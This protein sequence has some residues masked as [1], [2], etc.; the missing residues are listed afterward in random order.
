MHSQTLGFGQR[1]TLQEIQADEMIAASLANGCR[2]RGPGL[3]IGA[4][5]Y[6]LTLVT[7]VTATVPFQWAALTFIGESW[8][9]MMCRT[10]LEG[11]T[12]PRV[13]HPAGCPCLDPVRVKAAYVTTSFCVTRQLSYTN[14]MICQHDTPATA[15]GLHG[16]ARSWQRSQGTLDTRF[17]HCP[18][19]MT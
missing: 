12:C 6:A 1:A 2:V 4:Q 15:K 17:Q 11:G 10:E 13:S 5:P 9:A 16:L 7:P 19:C 18:Q 14:A 8:Q 3:N